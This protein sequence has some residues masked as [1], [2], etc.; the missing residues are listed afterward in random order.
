MDWRQLIQRL[1]RLLVKTSKD[2]RQGP[3]LLVSFF[4]ALLLWLLVTLGE[5]YESRITV[6]FLIGENDGVISTRSRSHDIAVT[7]RGNGLDLLMEH[8]RLRRDT[9]HVGY[10]E[11]MVELTSLSVSDYLPAFRNAFSSQISIEGFY[12]DLIALG[13]TPKDSK[14]V[15]L[16]LATRIQLPPGYQL[17]RSPRMLLDSVKIYGNRQQLEQITEWSTLSGFSPLVKTAR[18]ISLPLDTMRYFSTEPSEVAVSVVPVPYAEW[19]VTLDIQAVGYPIGTDVRLSHPR[20]EFDLVM[21]EQVKDSL[22]AEGGIPIRHIEISYQD[23]LQ[24]TNTGWKPPV[25]LFAPYATCVKSTPE[26]I[27]FTII[28][29]KAEF[30]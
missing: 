21:P 8:L 17:A 16:R 30:R 4:W 10:Q 19:K 23:L 29:K 13:F 3:I 11:D 27:D 1:S 14:K 22:L 25:G 12:P 2:R 9:I 5:T 15:P 26:R 28:K 7:L 20:M 18:D 6:P 24:A